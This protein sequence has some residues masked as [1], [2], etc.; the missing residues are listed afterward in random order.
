MN[1]IKWIAHHPI[2]TIACLG[3]GYLLGM[4]ADAWGI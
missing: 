2:T 4:L 1:H 3:A